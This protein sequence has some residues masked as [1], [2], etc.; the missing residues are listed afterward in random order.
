MQIADSTGRHQTVTRRMI[1]ANISGYDII[2]GKDWLQQYCKAIYPPTDTWAWQRRAAPAPGPPIQLVEA[3][4]FAATLRR[5]N[6]QP[7][8]WYGER[9]PEADQ[10]IDRLF[11]TETLQ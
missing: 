7:Y 1:A 4:A 2:L 6:A 3:A 8:A 11:G 5:E 10:T 9:L